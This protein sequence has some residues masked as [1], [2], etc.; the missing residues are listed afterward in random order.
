MAVI[1]RKSVLAEKQ[2][3]G[4]WLAERIGSLRIQFPSGV[5]ISTAIS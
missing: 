4:K 3:T 1:N 2:L 5:R